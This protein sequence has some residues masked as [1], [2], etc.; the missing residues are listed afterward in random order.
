MGPVMASSTRLCGSAHAG[1]NPEPTQLCRVPDAG[2]CG[3]SAMFGEAVHSIA[4]TM[5]QV[6][7]ATAKAGPAAGMR[8]HGKQL[9]AASHAP[10]GV[11]GAHLL[12]GNGSLHSFLAAAMQPPRS[13]H[14]TQ[15]VGDHPWLTCAARS[16]PGARLHTLAAGPQ[17]SAAWCLTAPDAAAH[18]HAAAWLTTPLTTQQHPMLMQ[19]LLQSSTQLPVPCR[20]N[21]SRSAP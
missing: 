10:V 11:R 4:D 5:N 21:K 18:M 15:R 16:L 20:S 6:R 9:R 3:C 19:V 1:W 12:P 17:R 8:P 7:L 2:R 14:P 13:A